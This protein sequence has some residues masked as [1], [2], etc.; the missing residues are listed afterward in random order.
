MSVFDHPEFDA[1]EQVAF[2]YDRASGLKAIIAVHNTRLGKGL[3]GC[4]RAAARASSSA[5][6]VMTRPR[7]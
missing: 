1:H 2:R 4:R 7:R 6:P 3:G 5:I